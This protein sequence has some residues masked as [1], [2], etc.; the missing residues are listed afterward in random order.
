MLLKGMVGTITVV[1]PTVSVTFSVDMSIEGVTDDG[2][3]TSRR[4]IMVIGL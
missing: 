4:L 3:R 2:V 1:D